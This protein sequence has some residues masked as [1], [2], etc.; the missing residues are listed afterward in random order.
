MPSPPAPLPRRARG[1]WSEVPSHGLNT[2]CLRVPSAFHPWLPPAF[3]SFV[4]F[5]VCRPPD[6]PTHCRMQEKTNGQKT[7]SYYGSHSGLLSPCSIPTRLLLRF[8]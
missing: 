7:D 5:V 4:Y 8:Y 6:F 1:V 3:V 2:D